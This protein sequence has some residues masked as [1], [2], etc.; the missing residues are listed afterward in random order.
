[1]QPRHW[2]AFGLLALIWGTTWLG[3]KFV[4]REMPPLTT[5]GVRFAVAAV[6][7]AAFARWQGRSLSWSQ[8]RR[9]ERRLLLLLSVI[10]IGL[11]YGLVFYAE[12]H[13]SSALT[14]ILFSS[15]AVFVLLFDSLRSRRNLFR[16]GRLAGL[17][18]AAGG[19]TL[20]FLP[21]LSGSAA[22]LSGVAAVLGLA[23]SSGLAA[24][25]AKYGAQDIDPV[26][27]VTWQMAGGALWLLAV[28]SVLER[29]G[30]E[31]YSPQAWGALLY[32]IVFGSCVTFVL[33]Y[34]LLKR[35]APVQLSTLT[36]IEPMIAVAAGWLV[37]GERLG[38]YSLLGAVIVLAGVVLVHREE[39]TP[40]A[41]G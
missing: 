17:L 15:H 16:G 7:L 33:Y 40:F 35:M 30:W 22:E 8:F 29:P 1:M 25:L 34:T 12:Q 39:S 38:G 41:G 14:A 24:V 28:G 2:L 31:S 19:I 26:V 9:Q 6:L 18:L 32:L 27:G 10:M 20:I 13:I 21:R 3:I 37:L 36:F 23:L 4:V 5:A 11:P